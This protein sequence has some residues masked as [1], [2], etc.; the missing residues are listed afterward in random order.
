MSHTSYGIRTQRVPRPRMDGYARAR[1]EGI[2]PWLR[3]VAKGNRRVG[4]NGIVAVGVAASEGTG[5]GFPPRR[6]KYG[7]PRMGGYQGYIY[8]GYGGYGYGY[9]YGRW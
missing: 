6:P 2:G 1:Q 8:G 4:F 3:G 7:Q 5:R 9:G